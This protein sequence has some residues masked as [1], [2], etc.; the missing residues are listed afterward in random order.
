MLIKILDA[1][2][3]NMVDCRCQLTANLWDSNI[4]FN[5]IIIQQRVATTI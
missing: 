4:C 5:A 2:I 3:I 1:R